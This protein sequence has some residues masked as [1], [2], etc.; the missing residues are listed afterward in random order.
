MNMMGF[1]R[2]RW[3]WTLIGLILL[4][5]AG[6]VAV[7]WVGEGNFLAIDHKNTPMAHLAWWRG[8]VYIALL[9]FWPQLVG[10]LARGH[11]V[12]SAKDTGR[13]HLILLIVCY[14]LLIVQNSLAAMIKA[15]G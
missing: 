5:I 8:S 13:G 3:S 14:E 9:L 6:F 1:K 15:L 2:Q 10:Y 7:T 4:L 11:R 12:I